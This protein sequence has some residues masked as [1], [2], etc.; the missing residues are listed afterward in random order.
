MYI[1]IRDGEGCGLVGAWLSL[2]AMT[3]VRF[4][5]MLVASMLLPF[6]VVFMVI[7]MTYTFFGRQ[8]F[9]T[10]CSCYH[11]TREKEGCLFGDHRI[12]DEAATWSL[13]PWEW[14]GI[15]YGGY[16]FFDENDIFNYPKPP[17]NPFTVQSGNKMRRQEKQE[18]MQS[19]VGK[20]NKSHF[21]V[22]PV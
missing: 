12:K 7:Y 22:S 1:E 4:L 5:Q 19:L 16:E 21:A 8:G 10:C 14:K 15:G 6:T 17:G 3:P 18:E 11:A 2:I 13:M 20:T 9:W